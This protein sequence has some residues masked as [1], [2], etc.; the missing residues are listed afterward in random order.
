M[1]KVNNFFLCDKYLKLLTGGSRYITVNDFDVAITSNENV[2][3]K[4]LV[5]LQKVYEDFIL[6]Y[7][8]LIENF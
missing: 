4:D 7:D 6:R 2:Y 3:I 8:K 1:K 5:T